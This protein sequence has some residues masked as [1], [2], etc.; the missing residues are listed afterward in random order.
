MVTAGSTPLA[1]LSG[2]IDDS[3]MMFLLSNH[4]PFTWGK[5]VAEAVYHPS[6]LEKFARMAYLTL[7]INPAAPRLRYYLVRKHYQRKHGE[8]AYYGQ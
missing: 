2:R 3:N 4:G 7:R 5:T 8:T 6:I 1:L